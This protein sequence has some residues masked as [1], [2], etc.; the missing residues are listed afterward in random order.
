MG[1]GKQIRLARIFGHPSG[2]L[3]SVAVDHFPNYGVGM[4]PGLRHVKQ[5]LAAV[6]AGQPDA[7][8]LHKGM[9][10]A[11]W[12]EY[13]GQVPLILQ[14]SGVRPDDS[15]TEDFGTVDEA[16]RMGADAAAITVFVRGSS[17]S[18]YMRRLADF[19]RQSYQYDLPIITHVYPRNPDTLEVVY[20]PDDIAWAVRCVV[21]MG[22]DVVKVPYCGDLAAH[23]QIVADCPVPMVAAGG[24]KTPTFRDALVMFGDVVKSGALGGTIGRNIWGNDN[25]TG[26]LQAFKAV[27]HDGAS[28]DAALQNLHS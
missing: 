26:A 15:T 19:V 25:I 17:E 3:C 7:V 21:E 5:T 22:A 18:F 12:G 28:A 27:I 23:T 9:A 13:A 4:P 14:T 1:L 2:K 8:T 11:L 24:P 20:H 10:L 16:V 6:M